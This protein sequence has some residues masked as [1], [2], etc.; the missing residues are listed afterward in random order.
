MNRC[1]VKGVLLILLAPGLHCNFVTSAAVL[2]YLFQGVQRVIVRLQVIRI[3][4]HIPPGPRK[5]SVAQQLLQTDWVA[6]SLDI[7]FGVG[8]PEQMQR[9]LLHAS[10]V[11]IVPYCI[12][13]SADA[14]SSPIL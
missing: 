8:M 6:A 10:A 7:Q 12:A 14:H 4:C 3:Q 13:D 2:R 1:C 11:V 5:V 9:G